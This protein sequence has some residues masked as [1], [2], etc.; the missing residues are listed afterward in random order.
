M[1]MPV[2]CWCRTHLAQHLLYGGSLL[3][4]VAA[5]IDCILQLATQVRN[6]DLIQRPVLGCVV[7]LLRGLTA[8]QRLCSVPEVTPALGLAAAAAE[9]LMSLLALLC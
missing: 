3:K 6:T 9:A 5:A 8:T 7:M 2:C 4:S 1:L